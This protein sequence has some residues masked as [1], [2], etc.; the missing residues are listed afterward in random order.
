M[1][2]GGM[3]A[4][5]GIYNM[6]GR[7]VYTRR[8]RQQQQ[9][10]QQQ[11]QHGGATQQQT[12]G[13]ANLMQLVHFLPLLLLF[14]FSFLS[15]PASDDS[16]PFSLTKTNNYPDQRHTP[17]PLSLLYFT[18]PNFDY[19]YAR[20]RRVLRQ[21]EEQVEQAYVKRWREG[22]V[23]E[24]AELKQMEKK[25]KAMSGAAGAAGGGGGGG[26][27]QVDFMDR[28]EQFRAE[29]MVNCESLAKSKAAA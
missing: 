21:V 16:L 1:F 14:L 8:P 28:V 10:Q 27:A 3:S 17:H 18:Q 23:K 19:R 5:G 29:G 22:C 6:N 2:F 24:K 20:D 15:S 9:P 26:K 11:H 7:R 4:G 25:L 13:S 12:G